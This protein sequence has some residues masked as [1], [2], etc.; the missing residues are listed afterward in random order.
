VRDEVDSCGG[1][2]TLGEGRDCTRDVPHAASTGCEVGACVI[3]ACERG[4]RP[5]A[6]A[7]KCVRSEGRGGRKHGKA[8]SARSSHR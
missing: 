1:C 2:V 7:R 4:W 6:Q 5:D 8:S 3:F